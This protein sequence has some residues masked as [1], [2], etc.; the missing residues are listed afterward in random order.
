MNFSSVKKSLLL[1]ICF[2]TILSA[3]TINYSLVIEHPEKHL[4]SIEMQIPTTGLDSITVA[5]PAWAPG[6]YVIYN[7][8]KNLFD[9][10]A[11]GPAGQILPTELLDKQTWKIHCAGSDKITIRY[12]IFANTLDGTQSKIDSSGASIN[13]A[14]VFFVFDI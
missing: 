9:L 3:R 5:L 12:S 11:A 1:F 6:R 8:S 10:Q 7:F 13:G 2:S 14:G 4:A